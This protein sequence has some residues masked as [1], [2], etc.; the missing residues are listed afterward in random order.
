MAEAFNTE[1]Y[2]FKADVPLETYLY[3]SVLTVIFVFLAQ[4]ATY[5]KIHRLDFIEAL[6][7]RIS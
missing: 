5:G 4:L 1:L 2:N 3:A 6:K 7:N